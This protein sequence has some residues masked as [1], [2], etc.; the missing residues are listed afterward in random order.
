MALPHQFCARATSMSLRR[1]VVAPSLVLIENAK[2]SPEA[3]CVGWLFQSLH[4][5]EVAQPP[6]TSV[7]TALIT[8]PVVHDF[9]GVSPCPTVWRSHCKH[10]HPRPVSDLGPTGASRPDRHVDD[11]ESSGRLRD[12]EGAGPERA[13]RRSESR[14]TT[15]VP[16]RPLRADTYHSLERGLPPRTEQGFEA[17]NERLH[18]GT[19]TTD[20]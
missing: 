5:C 20:G 12:R 11:Q 1:T 4:S 14:H 17:L 18:E 3:K 9:I 15:L 2:C 13:G 16:W 19:P 8:I 7:T 10:T 6:S